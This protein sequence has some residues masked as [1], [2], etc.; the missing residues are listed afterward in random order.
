MSQIRISKTLLSA[1]LL[2]ATSTGVWANELP[3]SS[4]ATSAVRVQAVTVQGLENGPIRD[5]VSTSAAKALQTSMDRAQVD[6]LSQQLTTQLRNQGLVVAQVV[7]LPADWNRFEQT[8][9]LTFTVFPGKVGAIHVTNTSRVNNSRLEKTATRAL[10]PDGVGDGC[11]LTAKRLERAELLMQ[12]L[13]GVKLNPVTLSPEGVSLGQTSVGITTEPSKPLVTG[14]AGVDNYGIPSSG[15]NRLGAGMTLTDPLHMGDEW[16]FVGYTT[17]KHE[18]S[19]LFN[20]SLPLGYTGLRA[21]GGYT[22]S[23]YSLAAVGVTGSANTW[24]GGLAYPLVR[25]L[26]SNWT[27]ALDGVHT[28]SYQ[29]VNG[30][31]AFAP[32]HLDSGRLSIAGNA[33][34]R[35]MQ[36]G[37][38]YW[39]GSAAFSHGR[40]SQDINGAQDVSGTLGN[41]NKFS[42]NALGKLNLTTDGRWYLLGSAHGQV[43][44]RNLDASE[45]LVLGGQYGVRAYRPDEGSLDNGLIASAEL[46]RLF[47]VGGGNQISVGPI[48]DVGTGDIN[49]HPYAG[50]Q[51]SEG[52]KNPNLSNHRTLSSAGVGAD[53]VSPYGVTASVTWSRRLPGSPDSVN[54]PGSANGQFLASVTIKF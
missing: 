48:L 3:T 23:L 47:T 28:N 24:T 13:P 33:G 15:R 34:D 50:W 32:R 39:T 35:P 41:Y 19:G 18:E 6:A 20:G 4:S 25:G 27:V 16:Q 5:A 11:T 46:R 53:W 49:A 8:G 29:S 30:M 9:A 26:G 1:A 52:Y 36:L 42:A 10:C 44:S 51:T 37:Q 54:Y 31:E 40:V 21:Q 45:K 22:H 12:D 43:A 2:L 7:V 14:F 38:S 17:N